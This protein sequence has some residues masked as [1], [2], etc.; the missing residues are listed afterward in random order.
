LV[1]FHANIYNK[2]LSALEF[3]RAESHAHLALIVSRNVDAHTPQNLEPCLYDLANVLWRQGRYPHAEPLY[4]ERLTSLR[5][6]LPLDD[7]NVLSASA[8]L[9]R[10]LTDWVV[11]AVNGRRPEDLPPPQESVDEGNTRPTGAAE[12]PEEKTAAKRLTLAE[13][14]REAEQLLRDCLDRR[15]RT[16]SPTN[17]FL[18]DTKSRFGAALGAVAV[19][20]DSL[21][22][23]VR[24]SKLAEAEALLKEGWTGLE[25]HPT[26]NPSYKRDAA[27]RTVRFYVSW[28]R[29]MPGR[30]KAAL[31]QEWRVR[32]RALMDR[33]QEDRQR[34]LD[35]A[36]Q[37]EETLR[38]KDSTQPP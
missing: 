21:R 19:T 8:S 33:A 7:P 25:N 24:S 1:R 23:E 36:K 34:R 30:G 2:Q 17:W 35:S 5:N 26:P 3:E 38:V 10:L 13:R 27:W 14:A 32:A 6:R 4:R 28:D 16:L 18:P 12:Q 9:A 29:L 37:R 22:E 15:T 20:D 31:A 11:S